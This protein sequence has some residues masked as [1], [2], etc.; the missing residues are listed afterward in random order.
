MNREGYAK[1]LYREPKGMLQVQLQQLTLNKASAEMFA[2]WLGKSV[3]LYLVL[4]LLKRINNGFTS[5]QNGW[6]YQDPAT[7]AEV[8]SEASLLL[9]QDWVGSDNKKVKPVL[10]T[11]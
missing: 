11:E 1:F 6:H 5:E 10:E 3:A 8:K 7:V 9:T 4:L 2:T